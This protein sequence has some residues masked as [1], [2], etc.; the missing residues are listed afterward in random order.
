ML[1]R[2]HNVTVEKQ[3]RLEKKKEAISVV[4]LSTFIVLDHNIMSIR[5]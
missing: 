4:P 3:H 2:V 5:K 1:S